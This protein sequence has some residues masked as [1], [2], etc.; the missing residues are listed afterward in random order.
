[1][2]I[3]KMGLG[4]ALLV[5][6][7]PVM[8]GHGRDGD[9][10]AYGKVVEAE[11]QYRSVRVSEPRREC[12]GEEVRV[13]DGGYRSHTG[14]I[15]GGLIGGVVGHELGNRHHRP[16]T[17]AAG[18][19]LGASLGRDLSDGRR[20]HAYDVRHEEVC[21]VTDSYRVE[22]RLDGYRVTYRYNGKTFVTH[23]DHA[24]GRRIPLD[25]S[26]HPRR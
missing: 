26:I 6:V 10:V 18:A 1:M 8:A 4:V 19:V 24:P 25:V 11:P 16:L 23:T 5:A 3:G 13:P 2:G 22:D 12:W 14:V 20:T 17:T 9:F 7:P 15:L 21:R